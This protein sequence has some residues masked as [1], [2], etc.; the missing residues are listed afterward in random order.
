M[1]FNKKKERKKRDHKKQVHNFHNFFSPLL[2]KLRLSKN[3]WETLDFLIE[4]IKKNKVWRKLKAFAMRFTI[5]IRQFVLFD[6]N[7]S[8]HHF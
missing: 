3:V 6:E 5:Q 2:G 8:S 1:H 7:K 4:Q